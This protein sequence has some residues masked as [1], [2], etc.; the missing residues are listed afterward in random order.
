M[1]DINLASIQYRKLDA[2]A[3]SVEPAG[4]L[5]PVRLVPLREFVPR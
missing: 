2:A 1:K 4:L 5:G 3:W